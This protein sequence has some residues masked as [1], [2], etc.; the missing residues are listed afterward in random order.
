[1]LADVT[2]GRAEANR[3]HFTASGVKVGSDWSINATT[4]VVTAAACDVPDIV[5][6]C[7]PDDMEPGSMFAR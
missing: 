2:A 1:M 6:I 4:P 5:N 3:R 7:A